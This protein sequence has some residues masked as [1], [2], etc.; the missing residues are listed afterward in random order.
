MCN[1]YSQECILWREVLS[2]EAWCIV[3]MVLIFQ[4]SPYALFVLQEYQVFVS[5]FVMEHEEVYLMHVLLHVL[6]R[7]MYQYY[8]HDFLRRPCTFSSGGAEPDRKK[9]AAWWCPASSLRLHPHIEE[10]RRSHMS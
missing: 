7:K 1:I 4:E 8:G 9:T 3:Y 6:C 2:Q 5:F 10:I